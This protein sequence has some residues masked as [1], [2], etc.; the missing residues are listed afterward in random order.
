MGPVA[1]YET[2]AEVYLTEAQSAQAIFPGEKFS[3]TSI[4]LSDAD[5][6]KIK[7]AGLVEGTSQV[8]KVLKSTN[9]NF[10]VIDQVLGKH[11]V[12]T[13]AVGISSGG[14]V[15]GI[16][17]L[18]YR[19]SYG[20]QVRKEEWRRQFVGKTSKSSLK[21]GDDIKNISGA[22]LSSAHLTAGVK[23]VLFTY[24]LIRTKL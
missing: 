4:T 8:L 13:Y 24:D 20:H 17:V 23:R 22:T 1:V 21:L 18:E 11:E 10:V 3:E 19:E 2:R 14:E 16:E 9:G 12:I 15:H 6:G 7:E 5:L